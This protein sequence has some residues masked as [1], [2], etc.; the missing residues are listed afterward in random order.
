[1]M[2]WYIYDPVSQVKLKTVELLE[3]KQPWNP[4]K[5]LI[6]PNKIMHL[7]VEYGEIQ[8]GR[9]IKSSGG[10]WNKDMGYWELPYREVIA[11]VLEN[12]IIDD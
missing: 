11:I 7:R 12:R 3:D 8:I 4:D 10:N 9:L 5:R 1:M 2:K 6:P